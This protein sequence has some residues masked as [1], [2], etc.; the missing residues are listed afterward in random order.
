MSEEWISAKKAREIVSPGC[1]FNG[2]ATETIRR[3][4]AAGQVRS[5]AALF[6]VEG[7]GQK[8]QLMNHTI[9]ADFW[10]LPLELEEWWHGR[11]VGMHRTIGWEVRCE[12]LGV[13]FERKGIEAITGN[14]TM[15]PASPSEQRVPTAKCGRPV[16]SGGYAAK[17]APL[18]EK[19]R[20]YIADHEGTTPHFAA[21][22]YAGEAAGP[23]G[24]ERKQRRLADRYRKAYPT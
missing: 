22:Q 8:K 23:A 5:K 21:G 4:A 10:E 2:P 11:F 15:P 13:T 14:E 24:F 16:G 12:A 1:T 3:Y 17:D 6:T 19:M 9:A 7:R 20:K 18:V